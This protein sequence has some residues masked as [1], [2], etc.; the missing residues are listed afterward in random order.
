MSNIDVFRT[1]LEFI[2]AVGVVLLF[3]FE[4]R[5]IALERKAYAIIKDFIRKQLRKNPRIVAWA[6]KPEKH[7]KPD[8]Q[9]RLDQAEVWSKWFTA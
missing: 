6:E 2:A 5:M 1:L 8:Y 4:K 7:G 9:F 3:V